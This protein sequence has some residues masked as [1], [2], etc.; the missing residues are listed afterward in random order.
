M[1]A[2]LELNIVSVRGCILDVVEFE[3]GG[4]LVVGAYLLHTILIHVL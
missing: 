2:R 1:N 3:C 4:G